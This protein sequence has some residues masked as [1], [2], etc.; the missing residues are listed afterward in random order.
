MPT[1]RSRPLALLLAVAGLVACDTEKPAADASSLSYTADARVSYLEAMEAF[2]AQNWED[3]RARM[4]E[5]KRIFGF[6]NF[7]RLAELR[8]ADI[9]FEQG[10]YPDAISA[11][12]AFTRAHRSDDNVE[13]AR[14]RI[15][16]AS[17]LEVG[18]TPLL[19]PAEERDQGNT[20]DAFR[21][22]RAFSERYPSSRYGTDAGYMLA[23]VTQRLVRHELFV[24]RYYLGEDNFDAA[25]A[26]I[27]RALKRYPASGLDA[28]S[29]VLKGET[30]LKKHEKKAAR[31]VFER[32]VAEYPGPFVPV[33]KRFLASID[34]APPAG[35]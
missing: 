30:L 11:Y 19:P 29:L 16:K 1:R 7:A 13:Y 4:Q 3:A 28:E 5:V 24:A 17:Y 23:V 25:I 34:G 27:D 8:L 14:Y 2:K 9:E 32:V 12:R 31:E 22:L 35:G 6:S 10:K 20:E 21:E 33:A 26:R 15:A 18:D